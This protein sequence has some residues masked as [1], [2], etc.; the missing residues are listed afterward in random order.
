MSAKISEYKQTVI[1]GIDGM[2]SVHVKFDEQ[3]IKEAKISFDQG[4]T[5]VS[6][7]GAKEA[8]D[9]FVDHHADQ[10]KL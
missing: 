9:A 5:W 3:Q 6:L 4:T 10:L 2:P 1:D 8:I 7:M